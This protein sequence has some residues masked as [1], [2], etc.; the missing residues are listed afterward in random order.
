MN[1]RSTT[2]K[3]QLRGSLPSSRIDVSPY[4]VSNSMAVNVEGGGLEQE[5]PHKY[6]HPLN[7]QCQSVQRAP[8]LLPTSTP[9]MSRST[10][11]DLNNAWVEHS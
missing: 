9:S 6:K 8:T 10:T 5:V 7:E 11:S 3:R 4:S 2:Q 1:I